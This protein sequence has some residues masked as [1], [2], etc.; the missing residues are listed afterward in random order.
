VIVAVVVPSTGSRI[1]RDQLLTHVRQAVSSYKVPHF[2]FAM[3]H[4]DIP[5]TD[6]TKIKKHVLKEL[7][8]AHWTQFLA[9]AAQPEIAVTEP[10]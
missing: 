9:T 5:R 4:E 8:L 1:D 7:V 10:T 6:S 3:R 2:I